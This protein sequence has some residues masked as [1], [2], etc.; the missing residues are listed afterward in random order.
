MDSLTRKVEPAARLASATIGV[1]VYMADRRPEAQVAAAGVNDLHVAGVLFVQ[2]SVL[3][4]QR[5]QRQRRV[6][7][8][9]QTIGYYGNHSPNVVCDVVSTLRKKR[10]ILC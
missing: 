6:Q 5:E 3:V 2:T 10:R 9:T 7:T 8:W 4:A 1:E